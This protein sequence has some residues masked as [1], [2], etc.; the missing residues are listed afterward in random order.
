MLH[1]LITLI[2]KALQENDLLEKDQSE[3]PSPYV[4]VSKSSAGN[5]P[6]Y[7]LIHPGHLTFTQITKGIG[8]DQPRSD[9]IIH[10]QSVNIS[11]LTEPIKIQLDYFPS[12]GIISAKLPNK[13]TTHT[14]QPDIDF[15]LD[16]NIQKNDKAETITYY[17]KLLDSANVQA[18]KQQ[19]V[20][21]QERESVTA[22][23]KTANVSLTYTAYGVDIST[24]KQEFQQSLFIDLYNADLATLD[25]YLSLVTATLHLKQQELI[26]QNNDSSSSNSYKKGNLTTTCTLSNLQLHEGFPIDSIDPGSMASK[27]SNILTTILDQQPEIDLL[28]GFRLHLQAYGQIT[29]STI[30]PRTEQPIEEIVFENRFLAEKDTANRL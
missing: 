6:T 12:D 4:L 17:I 16:K 15:Q 3:T 1:H 2:H 30:R 13:D 25:Q 18:L 10:E 5:L 26:D 20:P 11:S 19:L 9:R 8:V 27:L 22:D 14:L 28:F 7:V 24:K 21:S 23:S 29:A